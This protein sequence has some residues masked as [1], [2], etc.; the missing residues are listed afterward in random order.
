M[1]FC[2]VQWLRQ[3]LQLVSV[4]MSGLK[5]CSQGEA[6][7][8][9]QASPASANDWDA[10]KACPDPYQTHTH[11][12]K[13]LCY[14]QTYLHINSGTCTRT[15][16]HIRSHSRCVRVCGSEEER[17]AIYE[18]CKSLVFTLFRLEALSCSQTAAG[19]G[20]F[21]QHVWLYDLNRTAVSSVLIWSGQ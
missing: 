19:Q 4:I 6:W 7:C 20:G 3:C 2:P 9:W 18:E 8:G 13:P 1:H 11:T 10:R 12:N 16:A 5:T 17:Q 14:K 15:H 21:R